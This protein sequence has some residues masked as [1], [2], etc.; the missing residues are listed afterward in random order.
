MSSHIAE[1]ED[2]RRRLEEERRG[3]EQ[4]KVR[5]D[6][7]EHERTQ[8]KERA[9]R[10]KRERAQEKERADR[11]ERERAQEKERADRNE[12]ERAQEKERAD[13]NERERAQE[14]ERA[15]RE[16][17]GRMRLEADQSP[18]AFLVYLQH[19]K[20]KL[21]STF[22]VE[23]DPTKTSSGSVTNVHGKYYPQ[24]LRKWADFNK[25]HNRMFN[26]FTE[27]FSNDPLF[28]PKT[29][30]QGVSRDLSPGSRKDEQDIRP[31]VRSSMEKPAERLV[32]AYL[33]QI[34]D[35]R[36]ANFFF[37]NNAYSLSSKHIT[38]LTDA[39]AIENQDAVP[40]SKKRSVERDVRGVPDRWG[41]RGL[42]S[43]DELT[44][45]VGEYKAAHKLPSS[46]FDR[47]FSSTG[48]SLFF[49]TLKRLSLPF[50]DTNKEER[51]V[52]QVLCQTFDYMINAGL[53]YGYVTSGQ[54]LVFLMLEKSDPQILYYHVS[55]VPDCV[56]DSLLNDF[57]VRY[58]PVSQLSTFVMLSLES[59][60]QSPQWIENAKSQLYQWPILPENLI[61][62][63]R[64]L[65]P[66][67]APSSSS[68][69]ELE[70]KKD[71]SYR[72][73]RQPRNQQPHSQSTDRTETQ[74]RQ[75]SKTQHRSQEPTLS[76]CTQAC[77][78]GLSQGHPLD[79]FCP[80]F[81]IHQ[82]GTSSHNHLISKEKLCILVNNQLARNLDENC[83]CLDTM[84]M[85]GAV[86]VLFKIT[87]TNY[88]YT[89]VAKGVQAVDEKAILNEANVYAHLWKLQGV[90]IPV[91]LGNIKLLQTYPLVSTATVTSMMLMSWAG[92]SL[93][94]EDY[95]SDVDIEAQKQQSI[96]ELSAAGLVH[97]DLRRA[98]MGWNQERQR[99]MV[100]DFDQSS[101]QPSLSGR[102]RVGDGGAS[103]GLAM[104]RTR[105]DRDNADVVFDEY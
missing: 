38:D 9:D 82:R 30:V 95:K 78:V 102:K 77:L 87:L 53:L 103:S 67:T 60:P 16:E 92:N 98:N 66:E 19:V 22:S 74:R 99:V 33:R 31:F 85:F 4:E 25:N 56:D 8:E 62:R 18:T 45:F 76:Y 63:S 55:A 12:R 49:D 43:G 35:T 15:D 50:V 83:K 52:A 89:F 91:H 7:N 26:Q 101:I 51:V 34:K 88:G 75:S 13:R 21:L 27:V 105:V 104:K 24:Q 93:H 68:D 65:R 11:N 100:F 47:V 28:P 64:S 96:A 71:G 3:R 72:P 81:S 1:I 6:R 29:D 86:G 37:Q 40:P 79:Q 73:G 42:P 39:D 5:A 2:L 58:G 69:E 84:G 32:Q 36:T 41:I 23:P 48:E 70:D 97:Y 20:E 94:S 90:T 17:R 59:A 57:D 54:A 14:K 10:E 80:N 61:L 44:V 46:A